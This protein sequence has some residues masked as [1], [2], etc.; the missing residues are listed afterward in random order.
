MQK[1][2]IF[3]LLIIKSLSS[4]SQS[5]DLIPKVSKTFEINSIIDINNCIKWHVDFRELKSTVLYKKHFISMGKYGGMVAYDTNLTAIDQ[6]FTNELNSDLYTNI[7]VKQDTLFAEK[8]EEIYFY[9]EEKKEWIKYKLNE[10]ILL[11]DILYEDEKYVFFPF[12]GGEWGSKIFIYNKTNNRIAYIQLSDEVISVYK[13]NNEYFVNACNIFN[14][15]DI[16]FKIIDV[17]NLKY[18]NIKNIDDEACFLKLSSIDKTNQKNK[19]ILYNRINNYTSNNSFF[20]KN[21]YYYFLQFNIRNSIYFKK[22][23]LSYFKDNKFIVFDT[24]DKFI[25]SKA[26]NIGKTTILE[27]SGLIIS[28]KDT[29][30]K[31]SFKEYGKGFKVNNISSYENKKNNYFLILKNSDTTLKYNINQYFN[32]FSE[33]S[34]SFE[35]LKYKIKCNLSILSCKIPNKQK[36]DDYELYML[37]N[38]KKYKLKFKNTSN[39][40]SLGFNFNNNLFMH[41]NNYGNID[42]KIGLIEI[43]NIKK[44][45]EEYKVK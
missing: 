17:E 40:F 41:F 15:S 45:I 14:G 32:T 27:G 39:I 19:I 3:L 22:T 8:F 44:F 29:L 31:I 30:F 2:L 20:Y 24:I 28:H 7:A 5:E 13:A 9:K 6:K 21:N 35:K 34:N 33:S 38:F 42:H 10:P 12:N 37:Y 11:F 4:F 36:T 23:Y 16:Y 1:N 43:Y 18:N 26:K 25:V